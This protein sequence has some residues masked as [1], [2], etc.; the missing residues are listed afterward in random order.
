MSETTK[1]LL[2][3]TPRALCIGFALFLSI[4]AMDVFDMPVDAWQKAF[5]LLM[6]LIP[7]GLVLLALVI[8]WRREWMGAVLFP[9]LA[10]LH[11]VTKWGQLHWSAYVV[12]EAPLVLLA[13][14]FWIG[15]RDRAVLRPSTK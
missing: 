5:A 12:I 10:V 7:T 8:V 14:L 4:F 9:A 2:Y 13:A 11:L 1:R 3:W 15:W 6:H